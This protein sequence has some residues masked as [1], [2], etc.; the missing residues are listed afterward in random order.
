MIAQYK[1][2]YPELKGVTDLDVLR[3][4]TKEEGEESRRSLNAKYGIRKLPVVMLEHPK[5]Q[6]VTPSPAQP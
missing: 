3:F 2:E 1:A 5:E 6:P 4:G